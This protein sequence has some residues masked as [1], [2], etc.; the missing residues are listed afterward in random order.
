M[1]R[2]ILV[3]ISGYFGA[4]HFSIEAES[5][6]YSRRGDI[7]FEFYSGKQPTSRSFDAIYKEPIK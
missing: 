1:G 2:R 7:D 4:I 5:V 6:F 3:S